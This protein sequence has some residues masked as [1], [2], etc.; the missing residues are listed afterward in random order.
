M[1][2]KRPNQNHFLVGLQECSIYSPRGAGVAC[3]EAHSLPAA[4]GENHSWC[5]CKI[6]YSARTISNSLVKGD[7]KYNFPPVISIILVDFEIPE[8][9]GKD[10]FMMHVTLKDDENKIH[11]LY[12]DCKISKLSDMEK[13]E[14]EIC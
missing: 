2:K 11:E 9:K 1:K 12:E 6:A 14:Y 5:Y 8:L 7:R 4:E 10:D 13:N 3:A